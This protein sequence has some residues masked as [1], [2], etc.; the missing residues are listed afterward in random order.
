MIKT[1]LL[2][3]A[4]GLALAAPAAQ[5]AIQ[6]WTVAGTVDSGSL[7]GTSYSGSFSFDDSALVGAGSEYLPVASLDF[8][9]EGVHFDAAD[10]AAGSIAEVAFEAGVFLGLS[11]IV[12]A[13]AHPF[14]LIPGFAD[15]SDAYFAYDAVLPALGGAGDAIYAPVPEPKDWL[16][17][18][19]GLGIVGLMVE[20]N[21]RRVV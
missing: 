21:K 14:A 3:V 5:A 18:L 19:A 17:M 13:A 9:F 20:R 12:D 10:A 6:T 7:L 1:H 16:L 15:S 2:A 8:V 4:L 11:Y